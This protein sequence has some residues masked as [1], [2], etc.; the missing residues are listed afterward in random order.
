MQRHCIHCHEPELSGRLVDLVT[1]ETGREEAAVL[2]AVRHGALSDGPLSGWQ[3]VHPY[4]RVLLP[5]KKSYLQHA[6]CS[7]APVSLNVARAVLSTLREREPERTRLYSI[8][9]RSSPLLERS[10]ERS[11]D[12]RVT[13]AALSTASLVDLRDLLAERSAEV[14]LAAPHPSPSS[15]SRASDAAAPIHLFR[16]IRREKRP[17][18]HPKPT[19]P[20]RL[21]VLGRERARELLLS[22]SSTDS[23][24]GTATSAAEKSHAEKRHSAG[25]DRQSPSASELQRGAPTLP[26][27]ASRNE[28]E[29]MVSTTAAISKRVG[30]AQEGAAES[31]EISHTK[32]GRSRHKAKVQETDSG[33]ETAAMRTAEVERLWTRLPSIMLGSS[34]AGAVFVSGS[35]AAAASTPATMPR[36]SASSAASD[37]LRQQL[38]LT[39]AFGNQRGPPTR[40]Q[41]VGSAIRSSPQSLA[42]LDKQRP[43]P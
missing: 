32:G 13:G 20:S 38:H 21:Y 7:P 33:T 35:S 42:H 24:V 28:D 37:L 30:S 6:E 8:L 40:L 4:P 39:P 11:P 5:K 17:S 36:S 2:R 9:A 23:L 34:S 22:Q 1:E 19:A 25:V 31:A 41:L 43:I 26:P 16:K 29:R 3:P 15:S 18:E 27:I 14:P 10:A 12:I